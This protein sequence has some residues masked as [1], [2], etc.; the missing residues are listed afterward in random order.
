MG[1][2]LSRKSIL[3]GAAAHHNPYERL[4]TL[5]AWAWHEN[6]PELAEGFAIARAM[7]PMIPWTQGLAIA[8]VLTQGG[9]FFAVYCSAS[10]GVGGAYPTFPQWIWAGAMP[11]LVLR[12]YVEWQSLHCFLFPYAKY[13]D[14]VNMAAFKVLSFAVSY[15]YWVAFYF[16]CSNLNYL[17]VVTD[18][19]FAAS[20]YSRDHCPGQELEVLWATAWQQSVLGKVGMPVINL[21]LIVVTFWSLSFMQMIVPLV[22]TLGKEGENGETHSYVEGDIMFDDDRFAELSEASGLATAQ[23]LALRSRQGTMA[24][25]EPKFQAQIARC[26]S[27]Q[28]VQRFLLAYIAENTIQANLQTTLFAISSYLTGRQANLAAMQALGSVLLSLGLT[29]LKAL[30]AMS[31]F[32]FAD[33]IEE[34]IAPH[35]ADDP[36]IQRDLKKFRRNVWIVRGLVAILLLTLAYAGFKLVAVYVC[37][38]SLVNLTGC[39]DEHLNLTNVTRWDDNRLASSPPV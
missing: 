7:K 3:A 39:V 14:K 11:G 12:N 15:K 18:S 6:E 21:T 31:F 1:N 27:A 4:N 38:D 35:A 23:S 33:Y 25:S 20:T 29:A 37:P 28:M 10:C 34:L 9:M 36:D 26:L 19:V 24:E 13:I 30:E 32:G 2:T 16:F 22:R 5:P 8:M 17:D